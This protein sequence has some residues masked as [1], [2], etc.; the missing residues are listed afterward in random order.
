M[1]PM[2]VYLSSGVGCCRRW[3]EW[4][5]NRWKEYVVLFLLP[6]NMS[7][8]WPNELSSWTKVN[9]TRV[10]TMQ[11]NNPRY[12]LRLFCAMLSLK[13]STSIQG[14]TWTYCGFKWCYIFF[15]FVLRNH[16]AQK[17][18]EMAEKGD[19]SEVSS[20]LSLDLHGLF[21]NSSHWFC[22]HH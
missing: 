22:H 9:Q 3:R 13:W 1:K 18:I 5:L 2:L 15:R 4:M 17:A 11:Q 7:Y 14:R 10:E 12:T 20:S 8:V 21:C 6:P 19:F 16:I